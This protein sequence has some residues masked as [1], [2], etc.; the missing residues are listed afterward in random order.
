MEE[1]GGERG[2]EGERDGEREMEEKIFHTKNSARSD[3]LIANETY[4][5]EDICR[6]LEMKSPAAACSSA[7]TFYLKRT[8]CQRFPGNSDPLPNQY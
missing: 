8:R 7:S 3:R 4:P 5:K 1:R 2:G 6:E